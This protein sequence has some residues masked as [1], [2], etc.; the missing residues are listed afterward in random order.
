MSHWKMQIIKYQVNVNQ[1]HNKCYHIH[2]ADAYSYHIML[3]FWS[4]TTIIFQ[5]SSYQFTNCKSIS[6]Y[7]IYILFFQFHKYYSSSIS[8]HTADVITATDPIKHAS[9][10]QASQYVS[11]SM[12]TYFLYFKLICCMCGYW[13]VVFWNWNKLYMV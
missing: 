3:V 8:T 10:D 9:C 4:I 1:I 2:H 13:R 7:T 5:C 11:P 6:I 12:Y